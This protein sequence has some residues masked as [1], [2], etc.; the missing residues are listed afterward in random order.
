MLDHK[1]AIFNLQRYL[2]LQTKLNPSTTHLINDSYAY[3]WN[4]SLFPIFEKSDL[5]EDLKEHFKITSAQVNTIVIYCE[6]EYKLEKLHSF[7]DYETYFLYQSSEKLE[8]SRGILIAV[9]TYFWLCDLFDE[10]FWSALLKPSGYPTE[11]SYITT[12][13]DYSQLSLL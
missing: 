4:H 13:L 7:Y 6:S 8:I 11:A 3:A 5:H 10:D 9:F 12:D 2:I 1:K